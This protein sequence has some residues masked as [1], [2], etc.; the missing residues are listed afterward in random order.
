MNV[1]LQRKQE[2]VEQLKDRLQSANLAVLAEYRGVNVAGM[3]DLRRQARESD[4]HVQVVKNSLAR[5]AVEDTDYACLTN[6][7][8]G[9]LAIASSTDPVAAAKLVAD[10]AKKHEPFQIHAG[11]MNGQL[12]DA[13]NVNQLAKL[14]GREEL[15]GQLVGV[16]AAPIRNLL[17]TLNQ[18]PTML[19]RTL[20]AVR[21]AK[22]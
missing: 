18:L 20:A 15:I 6:Q 1:N 8:L 12:L 22:Q 14:P 13:A 16:T 17:G 5:R 2:I 11:A 9:P 4:V 7:L 21:D 19:V 3:S 10:F